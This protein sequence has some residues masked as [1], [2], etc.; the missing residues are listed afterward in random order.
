[1]PKEWVK[2]I[3][4]SAGLA[5]I[6]PGDDDVAGLG[7]PVQPVFVAGQHPDGVFCQQFSPAQAQHLAVPPAHLLHHHQDPGREPI[8]KSVAVAEGE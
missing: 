1:M 2:G 6:S 5:G 8:S 4:P 7:Q 3:K